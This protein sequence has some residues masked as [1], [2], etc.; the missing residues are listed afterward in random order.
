M[1]ILLKQHAR[2]GMY[3]V[4]MRRFRR[5]DARPVPTQLAFAGNENKSFAFLVH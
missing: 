2:I 5:T 3:I 4:T 1:F